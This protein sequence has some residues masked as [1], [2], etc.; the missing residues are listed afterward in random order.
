VSRFAIDADLS[1]ALKKSKWSID[2]YRIAINTYQNA[3][4]KEQKRQIEKLIADIKSDFRSEISLND[5]KLKKLRKLSGD[6]FTMTNQTQL[7][8]MGKKEKADWNK[9]VLQLT[10]E[11]KKIETEIEEIKANKIFENAFEWRFEFPEVL[12]DDGEFVG[13]DVVIGNPPYVNF[14]DIKNAEEKKYYLSKYK[15]AEYQTD[16]FILFIEKAFEILKKKG[17]FGFIIPNSITNN[18]KN[19]SARR[20]ILEN[21]KINSIVNT[22]IGVFPDATVDTIVIIAT[23]EKCHETEI[24]V[25]EINSLSIFESNTISQSE[26]SKNE[27]YYFDFLTSNE[28][29]AI[30]SIIEKDT[31]TLNEISDSS[32]GIKEYETGKGKPPQ[33]ENDRIDKVFNSN[34]KIDD[35][36]RMHIQGNDVNN[37]F[38][39]WKGGFL[40]YGEWIAA[41]REAKYFEGSRIIIREIPGKN[42]LIAAFTDKNYTVKN[43]AHIFKITG[44][45]DSKYILAILNSKLMGYYFINKFSERDNVFPKSKIGQCRLL[46]IRKCE[47]QKQFQFISL[48]DEILKNKSKD[49]SIN[50]TA[51]ENQIDQLVYQLYNLTDEEIKIIEAS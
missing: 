43:T 49:I 4:S 23:I 11:T 26:F 39:N 5:P 48:I 42:R 46:P 2:S 51:L 35:T 32:S 28:N 29:R 3:E 36:Y 16:L 27:N 8:D 25:L 24:L 33:T 47:P 30:L 41:P 7:F 50:T 22:P 31:I 10:E 6:L 12:N 34:E 14:R 1:H 45:F 21:T 13:F 20:H 9:K 15:I 44:N 17:E 37:Y 38:L 40:K 18:L 19:S